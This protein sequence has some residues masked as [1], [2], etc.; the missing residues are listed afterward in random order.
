MPYFGPRKTH[1][2]P[3]AFENS[4]D[5]FNAGVISQVWRIIPKT[6]I[7]GIIWKEL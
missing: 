3:N 2:K 1:L 6:E 4:I 7:S 5:Y